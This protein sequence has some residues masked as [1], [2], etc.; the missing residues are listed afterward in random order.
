MLSKISDGDLNAM[1]DHDPAEQ[2]ADLVA[3]LTGLTI[4][5]AAHGDVREQIREAYATQA[6]EL[7]K[8]QR[9]KDARVYYQNIVYAVCNA[10]DKMHGGT[11]TCGTLETPSTEVQEAMKKAAAELAKLR[12]AFKPVLHWYNGDGEEDNF[13]EMLSAAIADL[14]SDR[15]D[16]LQ[17]EKLKTEHANLKR[18]YEH[19][20]K[21]LWAGVTVSKIEGTD[22]YEYVIAELQTLRATVDK[23][24]KTKD[25]VA[26]TPGVTVFYTFGEL[27]ALPMVVDSFQEWVSGEDGIDAFAQGVYDNHRQLQWVSSCWSTEAAARAAGGE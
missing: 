4:G 13:P 26:V 27:V 8:L 15:K 9:E 24:P 12:E 7:T 23:L 5:G 20:L 2:V 18:A 22:I 16:A 19:G 6:A 14:Q 3:R 11:L 1:P 25:N 17:L 10:L 21:T